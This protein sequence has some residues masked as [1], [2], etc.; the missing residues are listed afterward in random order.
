MVY[1]S[2]LGSTGPPLYIEAF[3]ELYL[4]WNKE[5]G[6]VVFEKGS[7]SEYTND[8]PVSF[9]TSRTQSK[10]GAESVVQSNVG[11]KQFHCTRPMTDI[12]CLPRLDGQVHGV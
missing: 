12:T 4:F 1:P 3:H 7:V 9:L 2:L 8:L 10:R 6:C 5:D 11:Q